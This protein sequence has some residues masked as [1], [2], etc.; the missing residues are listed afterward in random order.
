MMRC[1]SGIQSDIHHPDGHRSGRLRSSRIRSV[2]P[3]NGRLILPG[4]FTVPFARRRLNSL[5]CGRA[6][7][8]GDDQDAAGR[9][10]GGG[11]V[12][13][14]ERG[15]GAG[16]ADLY[17][18]TAGRLHAKTGLM[19]ELEKMRRTASRQIADAPHEVLLVMDATTGQ[20]GLQQA[21][22]FT[23][24]AGVDVALLVEPR[25]GLHQRG[26]LLVF[27]HRFSSASTTG[28]L[29]PTRYRQVLM[30]STAGSRA[31]LRRNSITG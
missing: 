3:A 14:D 11:S 24:L 9:R 26:H 16:I 29:R 25:L 15:Q 12:R 6:V 21:R 22:L 10:P 5:K 8:R 30:A 17:V 27:L 13:R 20:N 31:A 18:D 2:L 19:D 28:A 4:G 7:G 23:A 1:S